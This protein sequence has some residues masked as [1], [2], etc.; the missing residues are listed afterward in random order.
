MVDVNRKELT[1]LVRAAEEMSSD[2]AASV[3]EILRE[4]LENPLSADEIRSLLT[5]VVAVVRAGAT[6]R[7]DAGT[8]ESLDRETKGLIDRAEAARARLS[9][10]GNGSGK[11]VDGARPDRESGVSAIT[12]TPVQLQPFDGIR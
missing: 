12:E 8:V 7:G 10:A 9:P 2:V 3:A 6:K 4:G 1:E 5:R 11:P